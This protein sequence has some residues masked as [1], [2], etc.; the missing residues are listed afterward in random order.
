MSSKRKKNAGVAGGM[1]RDGEG[2]DGEGADGEVVNQSTISQAQTDFINSVKTQATSLLKFGTSIPF[3]HQ[4][5]Q[6]IYKGSPSQSK[7]DPSR[8]YCQDVLICAP[9]LNFPSIEIPCSCGGIFMPKQWA[10]VRSIHGLHGPVSLLQYRYTCNGECG[11]SKR[12]AELIKLEE[13]PDLVAFKTSQQFYLT[14]SSGVS[15]FNNETLYDS[16]F[17]RILTYYKF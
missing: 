14:Q 10:D 17:K 8:W 13:C 2:A 11:Q 16:I 7:L 1:H 5:P 3:L 9:H 4:P 15:Y 12:T 6:I